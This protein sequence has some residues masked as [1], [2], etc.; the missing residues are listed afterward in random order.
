[1]FQELLATPSPIITVNHFQLEIKI[2]MATTETVPSCITDPGGT[3]PVTI[4]T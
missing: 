1:M 4:P 2:M 3:K